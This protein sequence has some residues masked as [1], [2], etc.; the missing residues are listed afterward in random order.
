MFKIN[1][2]IFSKRVKFFLKN[3]A[4]KDRLLSNNAPINNDI[5]KTAITAPHICTASYTLN[6]NNARHKT[7]NG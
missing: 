4:H 2:Y 7:S 1:N 5:I 6:L 3:P